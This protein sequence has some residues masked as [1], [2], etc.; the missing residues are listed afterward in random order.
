MEPYRY[1]GAA[2][3]RRLLGAVML[4]TSETDL[5]TILRRIVQTARDLVGARYGA[6]GVLDESHSRLAEFITVGIDAA[7]HAAIGQLPE[8]HGILGLLIVDPRPLRLPDLTEHPDS[9]GFPPHH[10]PMTS[11]L[12]VPIVLHDEVFGNLYLTDKAGDEVFTDVDEELAVALAAAA[13]LAIDNARLHSRAAAMA[14]V[15]ERE[16]IAR[17]LHDDVIQR[18]F[19]AGLSLQATAAMVADQRVSDRIMRTVDDLDSSIRQVRAAIFHLHQPAEQ[20]STRGDVLRVCSEAADALG[21]DPTCRIVG[22][23]DAAVPADIGAQ[24]VV[25]LREALSNVARHAAARHA[26]VVVDARAGQLV[27]E[28]TDDGVGIAADAPSGN[29]LVNLRQRALALGGTCEARRRTEGGTR[30][31]WDVPLPA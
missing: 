5:P 29:G 10:P 21:F 9:S 6:L 30:L 1:A 26:D 28:V 3:L 19:A 20:A 15:D 23:L 16:R 24:L 18:L 17:D 25:S 22:A 7:D 14:R 31:R 12:G 4:V 13:S 8:G 27:L 11:F 2:Q